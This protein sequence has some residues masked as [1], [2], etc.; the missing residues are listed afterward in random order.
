M[1]DQDSRLRYGW[2]YYLLGIASYF[3]AKPT[4]PDNLAFFLRQGLL[5][6]VDHLFIMNSPV[7]KGVP[8]PQRDNIFVWERKNSCYDLGSFHLGVQRMQETHNR[9]YKRY[10]LLNA[11][12]RGPFLP[13]HNHAC[14][15]DSFLNFLS[16]DIKLV[17]T[18]YFCDNKD[19]YPA[20]VQSMVLAFDEAGYEAGLPAFQCSNSIKDAIMSGEVRLTGLLQEKGFK[21]HS[22]T[23]AY[24]ADP[25][26]CENGDMNYKGKYYGMS[27][28]PYE[29]VFIKTNRDIDDLALKQYTEWHDKIIARGAGSCPY[30][31]PLWPSTVQGEVS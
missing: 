6:N 24:A 5:S 16:D 15:T 30:H 8:M 13:T 18:T 25:D 12:V 19:K 29:L 10:I 3:K 14:W 17:G 20:H 23:T 22:I 1:T 31:I 7:P 28:H 9:T 21:A 4:Q 27:Y 2:G 11:S 26:A